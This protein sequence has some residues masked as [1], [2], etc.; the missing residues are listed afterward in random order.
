MALSPSIRVFSGKHH[1]N[2]DYDSISK[3]LQHCTSM[4]HEHDR[5]WDV[6]TMAGQLAP[7]IDDFE[8]A[9]PR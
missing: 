1:R 3:Y 6:Q 7:I 9:F 2:D 5:S 8:R 4:R